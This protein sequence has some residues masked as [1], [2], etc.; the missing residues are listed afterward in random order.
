MIGH[1]LNRAPEIR[2]TPLGQSLAQ[3]DVRITRRLWKELARV[4]DTRSSAGRVDVT[5]EGTMGDGHTAVWLLT[6]SDLVVLS[7]QDGA[8]RVLALGELSGV[9]V[10]SRRAVRVLVGGRPV[11][12]VS[13][14]A[15]VD[16]F[17][18]AL[19]GRARVP[20]GGVDGLFADGGHVAFTGAVTR[21]AG[22]FLGGYGELAAGPVVVLCDDAGVHLAAAARPWWRI[23]WMPWAEVRELAV[24]G[25][26][27]IR[28]R[29]TVA[30]IMLLGPLALAVPKDENASRAYL[31]IVTGSGDLVVRVDRVSPQKLRV[32][33]GDVLRRPAAAPANGNLVDQIARL[34]EMHASG[35]LTAE[36]FAAAKRTLLG[37]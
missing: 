34:G 16:A 28:R 6:E 12:S 11:V 20:V 30:R 10:L 7:E 3:R 29:V 32:R 26:E 27:E 14:Y 24:E 19:S 2:A 18:R 23:A 37:L 22:H 35:V 8:S 15:D 33:L 31:T 5:L 4:A 21:I 1:M 13:A 9:A 17:V 25:S 36:E